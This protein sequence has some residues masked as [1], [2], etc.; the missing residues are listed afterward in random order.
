MKIPRPVN[1][2]FKADPYDRSNVGGYM[3]SVLY[4]LKDIE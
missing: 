3:I 2:Y 1:H 4:H